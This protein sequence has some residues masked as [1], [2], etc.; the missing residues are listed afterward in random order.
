MW[1]EE[2]LEHD[3]P[4][5]IRFRDIRKTEASGSMRP[6]ASTA[7]LK[8]YL[9][10]HQYLSPN[11]TDSSLLE[12]PCTFIP[13]THTQSPH[14]ESCHLAPTQILEKSSIVF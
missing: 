2:L 10:D 6:S 14:S 9:A 5:S 8:N 11:Q 7:G 12:T 3:R 1:I 13:E 4:I